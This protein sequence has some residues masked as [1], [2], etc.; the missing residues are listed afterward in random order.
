MIDQNQSTSASQP[1]PA[2]WPAPSAGRRRNRTAQRL[3]VLLIVGDVLALLLFAGRHAS[4]WYHLREGRAALENYH[5]AEARAHLDACLR[6]WSS[7]PTVHLLA[8]RAA[9][10]AGDGAA[11]QVHLDRCQSLQG[12]S[13][14]ELLLEWALFQ[15]SRG[16]GDLDRVEDFLRK[17]AENEVEH[18][19]LIWEALAEGYIVMYR[20]L[21]ARACLDRWLVAQPDNVQAHVIYGKVWRQ[22]GAAQKAADE[23]TRVVELDPTRA[24]DRRWL[25]ICFSKIGRYA[26]ALEHFQYL[27]RSQPLDVELL[28]NIA[29]CQH[30]VG[31]TED[32]RMNI[33]SVLAEHP[34]HGQA[35]LLR[36]RIALAQREPAAAEQWLRQAVHAS[37]HEYLPSWLLVQAL[38]E[39][40][41]DA[42]A[43]EQA[44]RAEEIK[45]LE[46]HIAD[47]SRR[48]M[49]VRPFDP[50]LHCE[51]GVL[52]LRQGHKE[53]G[54]SWLQSALHLDPNYAPAL[55][56][57]ADF[58]QQQGDDEK[59]A[60]YRARAP[61]N[62]PAASSDR[63]P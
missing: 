36:G 25:A 10:R 44:A 57:L 24:E 15:A 11:A 1:P 41:K 26:D 8:A 12:K 33:E 59:A 21:D 28:V 54:E 50:A 42:E 16:G 31:Q 29:R 4:A 17:R 19:P 3:L 47:V 53:V 45:D 20:L 49:S 7:Q 9:R 34:D 27:R 56:A 39:Q 55:A 40:A 62:P 46:E 14:P 6:I 63:R 60:Y 61:N 23:Y 22:L 35:L 30:D 51:L 52:L 58:Y 43:K 13:S 32:A 2:S 38:Q 37:P 18:A 5:T 48:K